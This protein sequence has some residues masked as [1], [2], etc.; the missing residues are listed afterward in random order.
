LREGFPYSRGM[1]VGQP[2]VEWS[3]TVAR[4]PFGHGRKTCKKIQGFA[5][6]G[7]F[8]QMLYSTRVHR[9]EID[10]NGVLSRDVGGGQ[11]DGS[12]KPSHRL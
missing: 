10:V 2:R 5:Y 4:Y 9:T 3:D 1:R 12:S 8:L 7:E 11:R 6:T